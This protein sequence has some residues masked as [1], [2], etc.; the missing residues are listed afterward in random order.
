M[1]G[2]ADG[3][4][5]SRQAVAHARAALAAGDHVG[6]FAALRAAVRLG[7]DFTDQAR[8]ARAFAKVDA[9]GLG[10]RPLKLAILAGST[11]D[12]LAEVLRFWLAASGFAAEIHVAPYDTVA[13][14]VLDPGSEL[15]AFRPQVVWLFSTHR[16]VAVAA[17]PGA[18]A[19]DVDAAVDAAVAER[20]ALWRVLAGRLDAL[21]LQNNA[22]I[23]ADDPF[24]NLAGAT[25][26]GS[27][28]A[29]R[30]YNARLA[31][32]AP[33]GVAVFDLDHVAGLWGRAR[34]TD[35]RYWHHSK[36]A[37]ALDAT[38][39]VAAAASRLLAGAMG[40]A[41]KCLVLDLDNTLWGGVVGDD[42]VAGIALGSGADG[43]A[44]VAFQ[45]HLKALKERGVI[46]AVVSKNEAAAARAPFES[47]PDM[48][49]RLDDIAVF[50]ANWTNKADNIQDVAA[51]LS[52]GLESLV[53]VDDNPAER[54]LVRRALPTVEVVEMP[55][56]PAHYVEALARAGCFEAVAFS[57]EDGQRARYYADNA[58]RVELSRSAVDMDGYLASLG[59]TATVGGV[60]EFH[61]PRIAQLINKSNQ[62]HLTGTRLTEREVERLAA[63]ED[64]DVVR[65][66]LADR[67][68]DNGLI[69]V[70]VLRRDGDALH[71]DCWAMSCRVL[72]RTVEEFIVNET[73]A[74]ARRRGCAT[75][76]GRY[77][78]SPKNAL[79]AGLYDRLGFAPLDGGD[80]ERRWSLE[81]AD[82][83][84][85]WKTH[86]RTADE[87]RQKEGA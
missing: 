13:Q 53:F 76:V 52:I 34:W 36:H 38:G 26:W 23:P 44:F 40:L 56:D 62:F 69:A 31:A 73:L 37:F 45:R 24:G 14:S 48:V 25:A 1:H 18:T 9:A 28:T 43:E 20:T 81:V 11:V 63:R 71:V 83:P 66:H 3:G 86:V 49:L 41:R 68:G 22:D 74:R 61:L 67:F 6:A 50:R 46:L 12:H 65:V 5:G 60:D 59:M 51:T 32:A 16:D 77:V 64:T 30:L 55:E 29:L 54:D 70:L 35:P 17:G 78:K 21:V 82:R 87:T 4:G 85:G 2:A 15:Y 57:A 80:D 27:R 33:A 58:R 19:A 84:D 42:G 39:S 7:D 47:H 75:V 8:V 72:G 10:L 79:V